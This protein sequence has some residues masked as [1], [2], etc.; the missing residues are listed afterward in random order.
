MGEK[1]TEAI[2]VEL[3]RELK[4]LQDLY[5]VPDEYK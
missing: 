4:R 5:E 1:G 3:K 2:T